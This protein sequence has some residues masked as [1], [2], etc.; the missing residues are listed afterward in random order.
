MFDHRCQQTG[1]ALKVAV[2]QTLRTA[3]R[4]GNFAG[5]GY[6]VTLG[7][8]EP[9]GG[10]NQSLL[11]CGPISRSA[12]PGSASVRVPRYA[13]L[14]PATYLPLALCC[15]IHNPVTFIR[16]LASD[17]T[18]PVPLECDNFV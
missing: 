10:A 16:M 17:R 12:R 11:F 14:N 4:S 1:F 2:N 13:R 3:S 8:K 5:G 15:C 7:C 18:I 9:Q 6:F